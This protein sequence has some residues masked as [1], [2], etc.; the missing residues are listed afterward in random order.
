MVVVVVVVGGSSTP[1]TPAESQ[2]P[3]LSSINISPLNLHF[4]GG[5][6][7]V[8]ADATDNVGV[9]SVVVNVTGASNQ[10]VNLTNSSG[11]TYDGVVNLTANESLVNEDAVYT[12][13]IVA[14]DAAAN[15]DSSANFTIT[16]KSMLRPPDP[17]MP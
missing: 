9:S 5:A 4:T 1:S 12:F 8:S 11:D 16:V 15:Q 14:S 2:D 13:Q 7:T 10:Q 6:I 3:V 17:P